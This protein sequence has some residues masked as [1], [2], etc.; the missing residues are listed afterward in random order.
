MKKKQGQRLQKLRIAAQVIFTLL[1]FYLLIGS[2]RTGTETFQFTDTFFY[3]DPLLLLVNFIATHK[4]LAIFLLSLIPV[5]LTIAFGRFFCGWVCPFGA[6]NQFITWLLKKSRKE[7][8]EVSKSL[9]ILKYGILFFIL[10]SALLGTHL[11]GWLDPFSLLTRSTATVITPST[12]YALEYSLKKGA[13]DKGFVSK[14]LKPFYN[15]SRKHILT[16]K[17]RFYEQ[18]YF[19]GGL[20]FLLLLLNM[21]K[22]RFF[23]NYLCPLG[24]L[25][26]LIAKIGI[27][28]LKPNEA[29]NSCNACSKNC[30]YKGSPYRD[31]MKSECMLCFNCVAD[32]PQDAVDTEFA[33]PHKAGATTHDT[34]VSI[35]RRK[36]IGSLA[37][38]AVMGTLPRIAVSSRSKLPHKFCR[39]PGSVPEKAFLQK[40]IR[41]GQ[42]IQVCPTNFIQPALFE[43]GV[44]G[45]WTPVLNAQS[46][47]CEYS[48]NKC[49]L[50]C[51]TK[52]IETLKLKDKQ[53]FKMGTA[54]INRNLCYTYADGYNCAVCEE[55][56]PI[57]E[58]AIRFREVDTW[59][60]EGKLVKV[61]Q[62]YV[63][64]D[65][66]TGC[67]ICENVCPRSD[68][69]GILNTA[70]EEQR[71]EFSF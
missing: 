33:L 45:L 61:K 64:P 57:P 8:R 38:G 54:A 19:I 21:Y 2:G 63:V 32:C 24:A 1:F 4:I 15:F 59:N 65:L 11:T 52:A 51:P 49:T 17:Q 34:S 69:P 58:K 5:L 28:K 25:Y 67:G 13:D 71:E 66:C 47:Y 22:R 41:C 50:V 14:S 20:F 10:A 9:L 35:G 70:E 43:S 7:K 39:P 23:C 68:S 46:G 26:G 30:T 42:C 3:F 62:I 31:Y 48:C 56:C 27:F 53:Q 18:G 36:I 55:L 16:G 6:I 37:A 40:C 44:D 29:C 12:N 60:F